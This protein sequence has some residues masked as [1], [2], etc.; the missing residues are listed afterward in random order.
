MLQENI[1]RFYC[2]VGIV[3]QHEGEVRVQLINGNHL[4]GHMPTQILENL[5]NNLWDFGL[6]DRPLI[7]CEDIAAFV[8]WD[9]CTLESTPTNF[10]MALL[11]AK[12]EPRERQDRRFIKIN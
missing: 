1:K 5:E 11:P 7:R 8:L 10:P 2:T 9:R 4:T 3:L 6:P 12:A